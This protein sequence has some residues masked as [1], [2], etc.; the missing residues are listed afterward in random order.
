MVLLFV[1]IPVGQ[2]SERLVGK[3]DVVVLVD[4]GKG[5]LA[6][7]PGSGLLRS[8]QGGNSFVA[9]VQRDF[10][11]LFQNV[12]VIL[13]LTVHLDI[14]PDDFVNGAQGGPL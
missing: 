7:P 5:L 13:P 8:R 4:D 1:P 11:A 3:Q 6:L 12:I 10:I 14:L 9:E 2:Q